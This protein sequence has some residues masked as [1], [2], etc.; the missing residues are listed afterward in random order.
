M[1]FIWNIVPHCDA[2]NILITRTGVRE[3]T[4]VCYRGTTPLVH[5][6]LTSHLKKHFL[7]VLS[8]PRIEFAAISAARG[9]Q[10]DREEKKTRPI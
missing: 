3:H 1:L 8:Q 5:T 9:E 2:N 4:R 10:K 7:F 6:I